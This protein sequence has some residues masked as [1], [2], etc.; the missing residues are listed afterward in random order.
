ML[1]F[2]T[3]GLRGWLDKSSGRSSSSAS[4][5]RD[6][7]GAGRDCSARADDGNGL[8]H[9]LLALGRRGRGVRWWLRQGVDLVLW[10]HEIVRRLPISVP[11]VPPE[12]VHVL[13]SVHD[14]GVSL[15][16]PR[17]VQPLVVSDDADSEDAPK[18]LELLSP[19]WALEDDVEAGGH[20]LSH[21]DTK[22]S[23]PPLVWLVVHVEQS[24]ADSV[25][26]ALE[27]GVSEARQLLDDLGRCLFDLVERKVHH[28]TA[29]HSSASDVV[30]DVGRDA[31]RLQRLLGVIATPGVL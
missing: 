28:W 5:A 16:Q 3:G 25:L 14:D 2:A 19:A 30:G 12:D 27:L 13:E 20:E 15:T 21:D 23:D 29:E 22:G 7:V 10:E 4:A 11:I 17:L 9:L 8:G 24:Q 26:E 1:S 31:L 6:G 18:R